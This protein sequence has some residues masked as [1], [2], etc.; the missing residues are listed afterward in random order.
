MDRAPGHSPEISITGKNK[1]GNAGNLDCVFATWDTFSDRRR[2]GLYAPK[3]IEMDGQHL[4]SV[5]LSL[6]DG[7]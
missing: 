1:F 6:A 7:V 4:P 3:R 2:F 5:A